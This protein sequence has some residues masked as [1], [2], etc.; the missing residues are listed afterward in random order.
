MAYKLTRETEMGDM[1]LDLGLV[2]YIYI[3]GLYGLCY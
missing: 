3:D 1:F 2:V